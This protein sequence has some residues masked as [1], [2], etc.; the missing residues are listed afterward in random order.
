[1]CIHQQIRI[2]GNLPIGGQSS[3]QIEIFIEIEESLKDIASNRGTGSIGI[4]DRIK[5]FSVGNRGIDVGASAIRV[6]GRL[7]LVGLYP[8]I[9]IEKD[10]K[11]YQ[12]GNYD[13]TFYFD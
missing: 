12:R 6:P 10:N 9:L 7:L 8:K 3:T 13:Q 2:L 5:N 4:Q 1:L 11:N